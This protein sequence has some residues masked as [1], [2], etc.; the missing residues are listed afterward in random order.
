MNEILKEL[1]DV[2]IVAL[3]IIGEARGEPVE[4][5]IAVANVIRNRNIKVG[6]KHYWEV[7]LAP[8]QFSCWNESDPNYHYLVDLATLMLNGQ[9]LHE[10][11]QIQI[12][13]ITRGVLGNELMD[14]TKGAH[15]YM[16]TSLF[17]SPKR[18]SWAK[19]FKNRIEKG[20]HTFFN[21][22]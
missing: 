16:T 13:C 3:T 8:K 11:I 22:L 12:I 6:I 4:G 1:S 17:D 5:Q 7:V 18:P 14:N 21:I 2:E 9:K 10:D 20:N 15:Y 19:L